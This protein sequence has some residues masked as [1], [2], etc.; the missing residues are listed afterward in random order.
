M[1][2]KVTQTNELTLVTKYTDNDTRSVKID[3]PKEDLTAADIKNFAA[4][5]K[6]TQAIIGDKTG[7][8]FYDIIE[9]KTTKKKKTELDLR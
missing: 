6:S 2:D 4:I 7:A 1:A 9:A 5:A 8:A 3:N